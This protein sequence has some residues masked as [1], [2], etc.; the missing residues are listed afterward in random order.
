MMKSVIMAFIS[1][2]VVLEVN[3]VW[4]PSGEAGLLHSGDCFHIF[5]RNLEIIDIKI[6]CN[7]GWSYGFWKQIGRAHV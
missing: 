7:S 6:R 4:V 2:V 3:F 1:Y 5:I